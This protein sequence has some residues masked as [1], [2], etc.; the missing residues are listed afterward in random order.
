MSRWRARRAAARVLL[1]LA[2]AALVFQAAFPFLW[3]A[4]T[5]LKPPGEV[6]AQPPAFIPERP[7]LENFR[8]LFGATHFLVYFRNSVTVS[9]LAV[10]LTMLVG[11]A[12][13]Y[14]L[15]RYRY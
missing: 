10:L 1:Y 9:G 11:A 3:M 12:G 14:S 4:S 2:A 7:T 5:S 15:T 13:A 6:F 8:R